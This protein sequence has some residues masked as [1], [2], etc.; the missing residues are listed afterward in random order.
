MSASF[1][2]LICLIKE[3]NLIIMISEF[4][5]AKQ[6]GMVGALETLCGQAYGAEQYKKLGIYTYAAVIS[7]ILVCIPISILWMFTE[8][9]LILIGQD[10]IISHIAHKY[11]VCLIAKLFAYA[12]L[13]PLNRYYQTHSLILPMLF[14]S[15]ATLC[16][17][18]PFLLDSGF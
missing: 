13:Q 8:K 11:C 3:Y 5:T 14:S 4:L 6:C 10:P 16:F 18:I 2:N 7:L 12:I 9:L 15:F 17:H 1:E